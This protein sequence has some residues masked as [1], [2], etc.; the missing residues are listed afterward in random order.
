M[1]LAAAGGLS[2]AAALLSAFADLRWLYAAC[3]LG[4]FAFGCHWSLMPAMTSDLFGL[5]HFAAN[6]SVIHAAPTL[7]GLLFGAEVCLVLP[8]WPCCQT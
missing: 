2:A 1:F 4:G 6:Q 5:R 3:M 7:G 8:F